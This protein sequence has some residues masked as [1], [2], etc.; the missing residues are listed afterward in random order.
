[1]NHHFQAY[2]NWSFALEDYLKQHIMGYLN[3]PVFQQLADVVDP[4]V[5]R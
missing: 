4:W 1:M 3:A 5:Y 2:G